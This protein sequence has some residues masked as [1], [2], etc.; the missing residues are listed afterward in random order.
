MAMQTEE[1]AED[2]SHPHVSEDP[3]HPH[4]YSQVPSIPGNAEEDIPLV[5]WQN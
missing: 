2:P 1:K 5:S 3:S 4:I